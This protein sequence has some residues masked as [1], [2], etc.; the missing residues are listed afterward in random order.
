[1]CAMQDLYPP[2][3]QLCAQD[4]DRGFVGL[5][6]RDQ[7]SHGKLEVIEYMDAECS[8]RVGQ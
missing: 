6:T 7:V 2:P 5:D 3:P 4:I 8:T 1:M